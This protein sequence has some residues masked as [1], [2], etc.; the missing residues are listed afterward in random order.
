MSK[1]SLEYFE[2]FEGLGKGIVRFC[3]S[4]VEARVGIEWCGVDFIYVR[5]G[6]WV[7]D[8]VGE[9]CGTGHA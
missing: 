8:V 3:F 1:K 6:G 2:H 7:C 4:D 5:R 9:L